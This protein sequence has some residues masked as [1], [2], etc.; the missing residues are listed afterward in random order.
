MSTEALSV[1]S[2]LNRYFLQTYPA[3]A[4]IYIESMAPN[5]ILPTLVEQPVAV[6]Q[7]VWEKLVP[8][9]AA[10]L[11][12][13]LPAALASS[14]LSEI[15]PDLAVRILFQMSEKQR[16]AQLEALQHGVRAELT[17]LMAYPED[18]AGRMM[19]TRIPS[20]RGGMKAKDALD[21]LRETKMKTV[22][23]LYIVDS[24][25][26]ID[27][28]VLLQD[29]ALADPAATLSSLA[30]PLRGSIDAIAGREEVAELF[31]K[32]SLMDL[33]VVD[34]NG[35]LLGVIMHSSL[36]QTAQEDSTVNIQTMVGVSREE[37]AL[38]KPLFAVKKRMPWLQVNLLTAFLAASVVGIF[39]NTIAQ[40][41]ALAILLPV[42]A[43]QSG[44]AGAQALA[45][46]MRGLAL[47]E[48]TVRHWLTVMFKEVRVGFLNGLSIALTCGL[49]VYFWSGSVG[50]VAVICL[51]MVIAMVVAGFAGALVPMILVRLGQDPAQ[52]SS[53]ILTTVTDVAGFF[54]FLGIATV[55]M[56]YL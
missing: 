27:S 49:G 31:T 32:H 38:S 9:V 46:T 30:Q 35:V 40:F 45:V 33:P 52:S 48:I 41:T 6:L 19:D 18:S 15:A 22:R 51:S 4:A 14:L 25:G 28:R 37:R 12:T 34:I 39:E 23:S 8:R 13:R 24:Q 17:R 20:Y 7:P 56:R 53:I 47:R 42:V 16:L 36:M 50:L 55:L 26:R 10:T 2:E 29:L 5:D 3:D 43:G 21:S 11:T 44:N 1:E 54:S